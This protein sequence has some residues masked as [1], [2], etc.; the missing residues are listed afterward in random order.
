MTLLIDNASLRNLQ[1]QITYKSVPNIYFPVHPSK[2]AND[3][4]DDDFEF[5][6]NDDAEPP[7]CPTYRFDR[8]TEE[9]ARRVFI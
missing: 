8:F 9:Q 5:E 3:D 6:D 1:H 4:S 7:A 2:T